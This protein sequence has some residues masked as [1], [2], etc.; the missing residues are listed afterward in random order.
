VGRERFAAVEAEVGALLAASEQL[1]GE[2]ERLT[3]ADTEAYG[4]YAAASKMPR[5]SDEEKTA[6]TAAMQQALQAA[7]EVPRAAALACHRVLKIAEALVD[8]GNPNLITDVGVAAKFA[9]AALECAA[10]NLEINLIYIKDQAYVAARRQEMAPLLHEGGR[11]G[12][13]VWAKVNER[14]KGGQ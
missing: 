3:Q 12:A 9:A 14:L 11:L 5:G 6:R 13:E 8:K 10:L 2:L 4:Q 1:R 7:A